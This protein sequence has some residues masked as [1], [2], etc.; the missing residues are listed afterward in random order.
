MESKTTNKT[1]HYKEMGLNLQKIAT[2]L[3]AN[4]NLIKLLYYTDKDPLSHEALTQEQKQTLIYEKLLMITPRLNPLETSKSTV[5]ILF[6][7]TSTLR[8]NDEF[9]SVILTVAIFVPVTQWII[10]DSNLRPY[11]IMSEITSS[12][13]GKVVNGLGRIS[14]GDFEYNFTSNEITAFLQTFMITSYD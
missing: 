12:L 4:D 1:R 11:A 10:K 2:R 6:T 7:D 3:M 8:P 9:M 14:G 5:S 13:D